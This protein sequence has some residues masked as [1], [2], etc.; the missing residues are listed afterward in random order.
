LH[1]VTK[2]KPML[3]NTSI[4]ASLVMFYLLVCFV[5]MQI[6]T[7]QGIGGIML[8]LTPI[9]FI[10]M[11]YTVVRHGKGIAKRLKDDEFGYGG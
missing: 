5:L 7:T 10:W 4:S 3:R 6:E 11:I 2:T 9:P 1:K 8:A